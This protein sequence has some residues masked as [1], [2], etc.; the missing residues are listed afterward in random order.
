MI[1][2]QP[3]RTA[4][5]SSDEAADRQISLE[6]L[7]TKEL[8]NLFAAVQHRLLLMHLRVLP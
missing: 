2:S 7:T 6:N 3:K 4:L 5:P 1:P 8:L